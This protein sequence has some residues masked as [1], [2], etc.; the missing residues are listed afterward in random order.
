MN[1]ARYYKTKKYFTNFR[2]NFFVFITTLLLFVADG[3]TNSFNFGFQQCRVTCSDTSDFENFV[4]NRSVAIGKRGKRGPPGV[5]GPKG[6][7][8]TFDAELAEKIA[9]LFNSSLKIEKLEAE[10]EKY[11]KLF[12]TP[13]IRIKVCG[14]GV[15]DS[16]VVKDSQITAVSFWEYNNYDFYR[17]YQGRLFN[18][19]PNG[20]SWIAGRHAF[21]A[22][23]DHNKWI[24]VDYVQ[25]K[26]IY[27]VVT[28]GRNIDEHFV[29]SYNVLYNVEGNTQFIYILDENGDK[30]VFPGNFD[31]QTPV[32]NNFPEPIT[33]RYFRINAV[34]W[35]GHIA[36]RFDFLLC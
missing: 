19:G 32:I 21:D 3:S 33:A 2:M 9:H 36:L 22:N 4:T 12:S 31:M 5:Q 7:P 13:H 17:S 18:T 14:S 23:N 24:Q 35:N 8:G 25:P 26:T 29:K 1:R 30:K 16:A 28:Q 20:G 27:G 10:V 34:S 11:K 6:E 15:Q